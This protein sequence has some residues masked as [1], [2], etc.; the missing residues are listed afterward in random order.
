[1]AG[2]DA[3][4]WWRR[5][6]KGFLMIIRDTQFDVAKLLTHTDDTIVI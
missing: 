4:T 2:A 5:R 1:M 3:E 6:M